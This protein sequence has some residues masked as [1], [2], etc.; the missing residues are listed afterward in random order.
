MRRA[1]ITG[2]TGQ[3]GSYLSE[4]LLAKGYE[5]HGLVR[6]LSKVASS[7]IAGWR[8][9]LVL[10]EGD[11]GTLEVGRLLD[12]VARIAPDEVYHLAAQSSVAASLAHP[13]G[14][15]EVN[16]AGT[17]RLLEACRACAAAPRFFHASTCHV[18]GNPETAPQDEETPFRPVNPYG[19]SK[20]Q[21]TQRVRECRQRDGLFLVNGLCYNHESPRRDPSF[22]TAR[23]CAAAARIARGDRRPLTLGSLTARRDWGDAREFVAGFWAS[24]QAD[25]PVDYI[26]ATGRSHSVEDVLEAAF[27]SLGL[28]WRAHVELDPGLVRSEDP[29]TLIGNPERAF[30]ILHWRAG[31]RLEDLIGEMTRVALAAGR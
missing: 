11:L 5:V 10:H 8:H 28:D 7:R 20:A 23:I 4:W 18:F 22:V 6:D 29:T 13:S 12:A 31:T 26:F 19:L 25:A 16:V 27:G 30:R 14:T 21:A 24:L 9:R 1:L 3:D 2:I 17:E 15:L